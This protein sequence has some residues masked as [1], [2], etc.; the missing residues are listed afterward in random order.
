MI[1]SESICKLGVA[2]D[3]VVYAT[4]EYTAKNPDELTFVKGKCLK[5][6]RKGDGTESE[7]W[8]VTVDGQQGYVAQNLLS[9]CTTGIVIIM[10]IALAST[11]IYLRERIGKRRCVGAIF[12]LGSQNRECHVSRRPP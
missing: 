5:V 4:C 12:G 8:W 9:V 2:N 6:N 11:Q 1:C 10:I 3:G 7:W